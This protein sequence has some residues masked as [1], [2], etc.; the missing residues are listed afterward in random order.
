[1]R[2]GWNLKLGEI[3]LKKIALQSKGVKLDWRLEEKLSKEHT[4]AVSD[5]LSFFIDEW[6]VGV[7]NGFYSDSSPFEIKP[8]HGGYA[9]FEGENHFCD[10]SFLGRPSFF[11]GVTKNGIRMDRLCK[12]VAPG[13]PIIYLNR[14]CVYWGLK[15]CKFCVVGYIDTD[16]RKDPFDVA[17]TVAAG[18]DEGAIKTHV[19]LTAG[20]LPGDGALRLLGKTT[21]AIKDFV[22]IPVSVNAEPPRDL[23]HLSWVSGADS[24]Y[25]NLELYDAAKRREIMPGKSEITVAE[26]DRVFSRSFEHFDEGQVGSVLLAGLEDD[27]S[28]LAGIEHLASNGVIPVPVPFYPAFHS[29]LENT[30][31]PEAGRMMRIYIESADII[32]EYGLDPFKTKA[33]FMR[34]G[35]IF[36]LKEVMRGV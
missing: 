18:V 17:E 15:Q 13:F 11:K 7:L 14:G 32:E 6:P 4:G 31:P 28:Y 1:M 20:A 12:M 21:E 27:S 30:S 16:E 35:A 19:A 36:A 29:R 8:H 3:A 5:Y 9:V 10:I 25:F 23:N 33:G 34:G 22:D 24:V 2:R 26:Y